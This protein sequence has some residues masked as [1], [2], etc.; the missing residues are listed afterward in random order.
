MET[1]RKT[2]INSKEPGG[3]PIH[4]KYEITKFAIN[5]E[6]VRCFQENEIKFSYSPGLQIY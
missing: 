5:A 2:I 6:D 4:S 3:L 1:T